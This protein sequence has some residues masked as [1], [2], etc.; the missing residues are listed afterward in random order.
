MCLLAEGTHSFLMLLSKSTDEVDSV[1]SLAMFGTGL[2]NVASQ[3]PEGIT[4]SPFPV[5]RA[6][7]LA[8]VQCSWG[9]V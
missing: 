2:E 4:G 6:W 5:P 1:F 3:E 8:S 9:S 7:P